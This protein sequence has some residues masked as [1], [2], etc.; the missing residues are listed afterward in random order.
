MKEMIRVLKPD[1]IIVSIET[2]A[3]WPVLPHANEVDQVLPFEEA[4]LRA[5]GHVYFVEKMGE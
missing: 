2:S 5:P 1:G 3:T 4:R